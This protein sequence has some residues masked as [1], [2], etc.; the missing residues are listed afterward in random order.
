MFFFSV[1]EY[2]YEL[3]LWIHIRWIRKNPSQRFDCQNTQA[4][5]ALHFKRF[6]KSSTLIDRFRAWNPQKKK[7]E[8]LEIVKLDQMKCNDV[9]LSLWLDY[10][11]PTELNWC[12]TFVND[13]CVH[14]F[15]SNRFYDVHWNNS[16]LLPV[17]MSPLLF[18][19]YF[20]FPFLHNK[21]TSRTNC[22]LPS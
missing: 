4:V 8:R 12:L 16:T 6:F 9:L 11:L 7:D 5:R 22:L 17:G 15:G 19:F 21:C 18:L 1:Y 20:L 14:I 13:Y 10:F 2:I 3:S